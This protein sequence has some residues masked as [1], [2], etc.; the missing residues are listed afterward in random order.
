MYEYRIYTHCTGH[1]CSIY[2]GERHCNVYPC[3]VD[4]WSLYLSAAF[5][6]SFH[7]TSHLSTTVTRRHYTLSEPLLARI[8]AYF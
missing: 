2:S 6:Y 4:H 8:I 5:Q 3:L 1:F 7:L